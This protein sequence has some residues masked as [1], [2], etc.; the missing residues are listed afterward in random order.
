[1]IADYFI[2]KFIINIF[3]LN[4]YI[5]ENRSFHAASSPY[6]RENRLLS[7]SADIKAMRKDKPGAPPTESLYSIK[8]SSSSS[9]SGDESS[10]YH[11]INQQQQMS[12][13]YSSGAGSQF[14]TSPL[15]ESFRSRVNSDHHH[16]A[17]TL[18]SPAQIDPFYSQGMLCFTFFFSGY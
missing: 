11:R 16:D 9:T 7:D 15:E 14:P 3:Y 17:D 10:Q 2:L 6:A 8:K 13:I 12:Q 5:G 18:R 4:N 1:M